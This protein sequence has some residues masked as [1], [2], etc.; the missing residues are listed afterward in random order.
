[1]RFIDTVTYA[2]FLLG[3]MRTGYTIFFISPRNS[4]TAVS[5]LLAQT[6]TSHIFVSGDK[7]NQG[8]INSAIASSSDDLNVTQHDMLVFEEL[9]PSVGVDPS[10]VPSPLSDL[11]LTANAIIIH[12]SGLFMSLL[13]LMTLADLMHRLYGISQA[14]LPEALGF[15]FVH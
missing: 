7:S 6:G 3:A 4:P 15:Y 12:S 13:I 14:Y 11:D 9:Y 2:T 10:F 8:L 5:A 1:M